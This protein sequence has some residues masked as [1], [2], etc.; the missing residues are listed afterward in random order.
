MAKGKAKYTQLAAC[1]ISAH[2]TLV[3]SSNSQGGYTMAQQVEI[4][5]Y[6][7]PTRLFMKGAVFFPSLDTLRDVRDMFS[8]AIDEIESQESISWDDVLDDD[9]KTKIPEEIE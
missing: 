5:D 6:D 7:K 1:S 8:R 3:V 2:R 4:I 9:E